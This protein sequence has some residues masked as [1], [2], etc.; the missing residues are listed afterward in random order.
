MDVPTL[1]SAIKKSLSI[2]KGARTGKEIDHSLVEQFQEN[3]KV[4]LNNN[5]N[6]Y[7]WETEKK[8]PGRS[9]R[10]SVDIFG[11]TL[12]KPNWIIE[13]DATRSDQVSQKLLS[14][15]AL[16]GIKDPIQ[17]V[18]ILYPDAHKK[19]KSAC[20]KYLRYGNEIIHKINKDSSIV[21][22]FVD[23]DNDSVEVLQFNERCH[24]KVNGKECKNMNEVAAEAL[25]LYLSKHCVSYAKLKKCWGKY[26]NNTVGSSRYKNIRVKTSDGIP[27]YSYT[28]FRKYGFC[29]Y[30][31]EFERICKKK[32]ISI[33]KMKK[34]Y[35]GIKGVPFVYEV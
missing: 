17:Y 3:I 19:G 16:W 15:T 4:E 26:V 7:K 31:N 21:G 1:C 18:A 11:Q 13:I 23:P 14:R 25:K 27:V 20:E 29:S 10:D 32:K 22:I 12:G 33:I 2:L 24:F 34:I 6:V 5:A 9:E 35:K 8:I 28:Q 30:W